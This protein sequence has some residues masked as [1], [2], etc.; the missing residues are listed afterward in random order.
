MQLFF[1]SQLFFAIFVYFLPCPES[2][3]S[4]EFKAK[5]D[6]HRYDELK[7]KQTKFGKLQGEES[8]E[9]SRMKTNINIRKRCCEEP[10]E[11]REARLKSERARDHIRDSREQEKADTM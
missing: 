1:I 5:K 10:A 3:T 6:E 9:F 4:T 8:K 2:S 11:Q 7:E